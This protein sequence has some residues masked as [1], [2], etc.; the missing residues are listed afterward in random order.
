MHPATYLAK[1]NETG[2]F[3]FNVKDEHDIAETDTE[4]NKL[5]RCGTK[6]SMGERKGRKTGV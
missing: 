5:K 1:E 3:F 4:M 2:E 6:E